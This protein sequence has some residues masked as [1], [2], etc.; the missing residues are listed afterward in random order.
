MIKLTSQHLAIRTRSVVK[1]DRLEL[2]EVKTCE[3]QSSDNLVKNNN[4]ISIAKYLKRL[5]IN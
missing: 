1:H 2:K 5:I 4:V 3:K